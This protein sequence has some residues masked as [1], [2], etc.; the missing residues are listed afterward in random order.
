MRCRLASHHPR[1]SASASAQQTK[2]AFGEIA[3][4]LG[5]GFPG[6]ELKVVAINGVRLGYRVAGSGPVVV[7]IPGF[8]ENGY[9]W[10]EIARGLSKTNRVIVPDYR[11]AY[12]S[13]KPL[14]G[15]D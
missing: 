11:G 7:L 9:E 3:Q 13:S 12:G 2:K 4:V 1:S 15:Y 14:D 8:P 5:H 10:R 6:F